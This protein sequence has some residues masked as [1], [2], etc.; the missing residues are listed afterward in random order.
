MK[1][2]SEADMPICRTCKHVTKVP[3]HERMYRLGY[4]NC[5]H[6]DPSQFVPGHMVC[7]LQPIRWVQKA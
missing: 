3:G 1:S 2:R 6:K 4:R 7:N 5:A